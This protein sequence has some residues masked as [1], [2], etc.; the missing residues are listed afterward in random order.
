M[1]E[2]DF[3]GMLEEILEIDSGTVSMDARLEDLDFD[4]LSTL[5][6]ISE[7]DNRLG[8]TIEASR[9]A[10][11]ETPSDLLTAIKEAVDA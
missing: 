6:F 1:D 10:G 11:A 3:R 9:I 2:A 7:V 8:V 5:S 4:S